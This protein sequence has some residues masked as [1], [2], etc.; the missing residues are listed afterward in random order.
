MDFSINTEHIE[1][2]IRLFVAA[3]CGTFIGVERKLRLKD[4]G[5]RTHLVVAF[6]S[7]L[8]MIV[9]KYGFDD[10]IKYAT[11]VQSEI[12]KFDPTRIAST[13]VTGIGF[14]GAGTIFVRKNVINGLTTAA[15]LWSTAAIGMAIGSGLYFIGVISTIMLSFLQWLLHNKR[16][17]NKSTAL[18]MKFKVSQVEKPID[19]LI[20]LLEGKGIKVVDINFEKVS[21]SD[22]KIDCIVKMPSKLNHVQL[23]DELC[24]VDFVQGLE[25]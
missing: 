1:F 10:M 16:V 11:D 6:G 23:A 9:S 21:T 13:I 5:M 17:F 18:V 3:V 24:E 22:Y 4:A 19:S 15:G 7:A 12:V 14:L 2:I 20:S 25:F 8:F